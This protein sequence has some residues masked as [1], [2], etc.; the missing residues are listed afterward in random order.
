MYAWI[1]E[2][3]CSKN[4]KRYVVYEWPNVLDNASRLDIAIARIIRIYED[5]NVIIL[6]SQE[7]GQSSYKNRFTKEWDIY[8]HPKPSNLFTFSREKYVSQN[9][10]CIRMC[11]KCILNI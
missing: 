10:F 1:S 2:R 8:I 3:Y 5:A 7:L 11:K 9:I 4:P 6:S